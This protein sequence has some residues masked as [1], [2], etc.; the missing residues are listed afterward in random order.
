MPPEHRAFEALPLPVVIL[1]GPRVV[2]VNPALEALGGV[3]RETLLTWSAEQLMAHFLPQERAWMEP[4]READVRGEPTPQELWLRVRTADGSQRLFWLRW[5]EGPRE[6][7]RTM[8][9]LDAEGEANTRRLTEALAAAAGE[10]MGCRTE[11]AVLEAT[12]ETIHRQGFWVATLLVQGEALVH[13]PMRQDPDT[14][15]AG[16]Q[17]Y[18]MPIQ[19]V[20][21]P[22]GSLPHLEELFSSGRIAFHQDIHRVLDSFHSP[23][24]A[25]LLKRTFPSMRALDAP[26]FVDGR[27]YGVLALHGDALNPASAATLGLFARQ[28]GSAL[29]N[30][31]HHAQAARQLTELRRLQGELVDRERLAVLGEAAAV[32]AH[33]VR[34]P[35]GAILNAAAVVRRDPAGPYAAR[36]AAMLEEEALRLETVVRDLLDVVRPLEPRPRPLQLEELARRVLGL[37]VER[38]EAAADQLLLDEEPQL[39]EL[40][41]DQSLLQLALENLVRNAVQASPPGSPVHVRITRTQDGVCLSV[42]DRGT[43]LAEADAERVFE[44]FFTTRATGTGLGLSVVRRVVHAHGGSVRAAPRDGGGARFELRLPLRCA[45]P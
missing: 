15:A 2:H 40:H 43:G 29:E 10:L 19:Q 21:F 5:C 8:L 18:G 22:R 32:V 1:E 4:M 45:T 20:R 36:A 7:E 28:V 11:E 34:N 41:A 39:P 30:V 24:V 33:E 6:G 37:F 44:P 42:E 9:M 3:P 25:A 35:L 14:V 27:A 31:R 12:V 17:L 13:G 23:E 38:G 26:L 16:E